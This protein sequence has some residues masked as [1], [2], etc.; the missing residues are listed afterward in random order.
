V[1]AA[2]TMILAMDLW[3][4]VRAVAGG[5]AAAVA[6]ENV[7]RRH[8]LAALPDRWFMVVFLS[9]FGPV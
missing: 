5:S 1:G 6:V 2:V 7:A 9:Q 4:F 8:Q 3:S